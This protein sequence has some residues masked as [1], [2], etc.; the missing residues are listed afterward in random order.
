MSEEDEKRY[1]ELTAEVM[2]DFKDALN[3]YSK[4]MGKPLGD[5]LPSYTEWAN[6]ETKIVKER[7]EKEMKK[8]QLK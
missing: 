4:L 3:S 5:L 6:L 2:S 8:E 1:A 7:L